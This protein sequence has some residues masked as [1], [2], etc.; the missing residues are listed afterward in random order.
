MSNHFTK[1]SKLMKIKIRAVKFK[2][3]VNYSVTHIAWII[4]FVLVRMFIW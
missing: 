2:V 4:R 3:H 1:L